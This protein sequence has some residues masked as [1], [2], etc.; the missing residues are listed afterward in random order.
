MEKKDE[1]LTDLKTQSSGDIW[2]K[3]AIVTVDKTR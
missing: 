3:P 2:K 1:S